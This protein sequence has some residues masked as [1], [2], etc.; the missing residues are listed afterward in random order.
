MLFPVFSTAKEKTKASGCISNERQIGL[1]MTL[2]N[3]DF[4]ERFPIASS[5][6]SRFTR[7]EGKTPS[8]LP[9]LSE[10]MKPYVKSA[11]LWR[12]P[13]DKGVPMVQK[14]DFSES[15]ECDLP[16]DPSVFISHGSS[17]AFREDLG[18]RHAS[19]PVTLYDPYS[20]KEHGPSE[21]AYLYDIHGAWHG[22]PAP[23]AKRY[24]G[25]FLDGHIRLIR[26]PDIAEMEAWEPR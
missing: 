22:G 9:L 12:C 1:S 19:N 6:Q 11:E 20:K 13:V 7:C 23:S 15:S 2:Y 5:P 16:G 8:S 18:L 21:L 3:A 17:Y 4:D 24:Q 26:L 25:L 10:V 14:N